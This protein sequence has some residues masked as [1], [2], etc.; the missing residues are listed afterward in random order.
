[1]I[2]YVFQDNTSWMDSLFRASEAD[3]ECAEMLMC[4]K[5]F[6]CVYVYVQVRTNRGVWILKKKKL[7]LFLSRQ[8]AI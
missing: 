5:T 3:A 8:T 6:P 1:M 4:V 2:L 7:G